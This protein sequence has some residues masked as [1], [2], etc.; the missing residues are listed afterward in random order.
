MVFH[1]PESLSVAGIAE[2]G[3]QRCQNSERELTGGK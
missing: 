2:M 3:K 1:L